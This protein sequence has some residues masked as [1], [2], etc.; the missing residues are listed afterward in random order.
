LAPPLFLEIAL[1]H[2]KQAWRGYR[3]GRLSREFEEIKEKIKSLE[4]GD[5]QIK[6]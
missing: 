3:L 1:R 4:K 5:P 2:I 6:Q